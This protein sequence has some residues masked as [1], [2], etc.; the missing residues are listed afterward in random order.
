[1]SQEPLQVWVTADGRRIPIP[2]MT[3]S[4]LNNALTYLE[5]TAEAR[6]DAEVSYFVHNVN[7]RSERSLEVFD[8]EMEHILC[9]PIQDWL[10]SDDTYRALR[11]EQVKR[12][13]DKLEADMERRERI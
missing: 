8:A 10:D 7:L 4:H 11:D 2:E 9:A 3:D 5:R 13:I 1:M 12:V 6:R